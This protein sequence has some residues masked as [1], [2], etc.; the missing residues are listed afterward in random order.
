MARVNTQIS[1]TREDRLQL[2][3]MA[4][5]KSLPHGLVQRAQIVL[6][7]ADGDSRH[8]RFFVGIK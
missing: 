3:S 5:S 1:L 6:M 4:R 8:K 7:S 2:E